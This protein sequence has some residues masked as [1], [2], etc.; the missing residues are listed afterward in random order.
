[1]KSFKYI[2]IAILMFSSLPSML[3]KAESKIK[4]H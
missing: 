4:A 3:T 2:L 1:M